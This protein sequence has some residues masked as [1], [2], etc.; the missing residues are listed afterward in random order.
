[1]LEEGYTLE[2]FEGDIF[3]PAGWSRNEGWKTMEGMATSGVKSVT[4]GGMMTCD[5]VSPRLDL[6]AGNGK[7]KFDYIETTGEEYIDD[8][9]YRQHI[10]FFII[11]KIPIPIGRSC[12]VLL[13]IVSIM[14]GYKKKSRLKTQMEIS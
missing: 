10:S 11:R 4:V 2:S 1:M 13:M 8:S 3:P 6:S 12:G 14:N 5:I 7:V 9:F